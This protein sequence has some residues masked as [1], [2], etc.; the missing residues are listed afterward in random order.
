MGAFV[1][2]AASC[3]FLYYALMPMV[4]SEAAAKFCWALVFLFIAFAC[5]TSK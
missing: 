2:L 1:S 5:E 3:G 4:G